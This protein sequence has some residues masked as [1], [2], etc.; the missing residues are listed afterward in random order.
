MAK[1]PKIRFKNFS[2]EW[3]EHK[4][5][6]YF[7]ER[8]E[9]SN[10]GELISVTINSGI[11][12]FY[13][14]GRHD[15]SSDDKS[16]YKRVEIDD[17]AYNSMRMWQGAS[18]RS[19][20]SGILSPAYTVVIPKE[21]INSVF[22]SYVF[23]LPNMI[24]KFKIHSQGLTTDTWNLK[25]PAFAE[26]E[27]SKPKIAEQCKISEFFTK[28]DK[29]ISLHQSKFEKLQKIKK[30]CLQNL[31]PQNN[32]NT[33]KIRFKNF[34]DEWVENKLGEILIEQNNRTSNFNENPLYSLTIEN[35][36]TKK[37]ERYERDFLVKKTE[38]LFK[39]VQPNEFVTNPMNFR[40]GAFGYNN[41][42]YKISVSGYY[43]VFSI[44]N[45]QC[46]HFWYAY[47]KTPL[48]LLKFN[49]VATGSLIEKRRVKF[50][51]LQEIIFISPQSMAEKKQISDFFS[52]LDKLI[53]L[54]QSKFK[55]LQ[56]IKKSCLQNMF[57]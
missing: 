23:K 45:N 16:N 43:D 1:T 3:V 32:Q 41:N 51:T 18:G 19:P 37:T 22:F 49:N 30:S 25:F 55:K 27:A 6:D 21:G 40:F 2:D 39:I 47:F 56:K 42:K 35:G 33:P 31:F 53:T 13:E 44:D 26:I 15:N 48:S 4:L 14:L 9:R 10:I 57:V 46:S 52:K 28:L 12:K 17:I 24:Y 36:I 38:D 5:G 50:S 11:R 8:V 54:H 34:N 7:T 29:L 20:Y